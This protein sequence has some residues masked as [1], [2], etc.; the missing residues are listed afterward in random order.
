[1]V[2]LFGRV[3]TVT[4]WGS[5]FETARRLAYEE[6]ATVRFSGAVYRRDIG[7]KAGVSA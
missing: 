5:D 7:A 1:M 4:A 2:N 6:V 3:A